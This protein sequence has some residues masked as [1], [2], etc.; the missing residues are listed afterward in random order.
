M[1]DISPAELES[2][3][4]LSS[5]LSL[6]E[7]NA[8]SAVPKALIG[9]LR[10]ANHHCRPNARLDAAGQ[11]QVQAVAIKRI[12]VGDEITVTYASDYFGTNNQECGCNH[13]KPTP[14]QVQVRDP[15]ASQQQA[16]IQ[17]HRLI[18]GLGVADSPPPRLHQRRLR[19][20][21]AA[22]FPHPMTF[23]SP[24][25]V[26]SKLNSIKSAQIRQNIIHSP[27]PSRTSGLMPP[28]KLSYILCGDCQSAVPNS[29][30]R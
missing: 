16:I 30:L 24:S 10:F 12:N 25:R 18:Y 28:T 21:V 17:R 1:V 11:S 3:N 13:C 2:D 6:I 5:H 14:R 19:S 7:V 20:T 29:T 4:I 23:N 22:Q 9:P 26:S 27:T 8:Q 15:F